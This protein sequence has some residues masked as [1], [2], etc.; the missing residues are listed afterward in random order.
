M[1]EQSHKLIVVRRDGRVMETTFGGW[2]AES[3]SDR[4]F[5]EVIKDER[6][7]FATTIVNGGEYG[8]QWF[9]DEERALT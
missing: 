6:T 4:E 5:T 3:L 2:G 1:T 8:R 9:A 7:I